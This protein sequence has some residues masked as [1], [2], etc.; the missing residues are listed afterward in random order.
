MLICREALC[1]IGPFDEKRKTGDA[2]EWL[3][4]MQNFNLPTSRIDFIAA[5]RRLHQMNTGRLHRMQEKKDYAAIL[6]EHLK[7]R[8]LDLL[9]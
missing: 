9:V 6:R 3:L 5:D 8:V 4:R 2:V 7:T 1:K